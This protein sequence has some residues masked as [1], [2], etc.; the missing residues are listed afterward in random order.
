M[1]CPICLQQNEDTLVKL[2]CL[3][4]YHDSCVAQ[5]L[6]ICKCCPMCRVPVK[7]TS[8]YLSALFKV[9]TPDQILSFIFSTRVDE[10]II[11]QLFKDKRLREYDIVLL[12]SLG[13]ITDEWLIYEISEG[14]M[15]S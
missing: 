11:V 10:N 7:E 8:R 12:V 9:L 2:D 5:W 6:Q 1:T 15:Y 3:H 13:Y 4:E 14:F